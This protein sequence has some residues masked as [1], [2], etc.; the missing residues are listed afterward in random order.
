MYHRSAGELAVS[1]KSLEEYGLSLGQLLMSILLVVL[2]VLTYYV[3]PSSF[4]YGKFEVFFGIL[5]SL[6]LMMILGLTFVSVLLLPMVQRG[7]L[8]IFL[9]FCR[10]DRKLKQVIL[11]NL[12]SHKKRNTKTAIMFAI[13]L[14]FLIFAGSTF[15]LLGRM[16]EAGLET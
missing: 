6:L 11:K 10:K 12:E 8:S 2:G 5:N 4:L 9:C 14:S 15:A 1:I 16:I 7:L 3:A 13:C